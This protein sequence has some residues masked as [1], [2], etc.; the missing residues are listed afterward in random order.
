MVMDFFLRME[1]QVSLKEEVYSNFCV[2]DNMF[3]SITTAVASDEDE[4][5]SA[6]EASVGERIA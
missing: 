6:K 4:L 2:Q 5:P 3:C 1:H